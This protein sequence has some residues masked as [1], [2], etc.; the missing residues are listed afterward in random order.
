MILVYHI[1]PWRVQVPTN[2]AVHQL[3]MCIQLKA[4]SPC[5]HNY[6][7]DEWGK[8]KNQ[9]LD[10]VLFEWSLC[11]SVWKFFK[12]KPKVLYTLWPLMVNLDIYSINFILLYIEIAT[13][14]PLEKGCDFKRFRDCT[15]EEWRMYKKRLSQIKR[16]MLSKWLR[17]K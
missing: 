7:V 2:D 6:R 11:S 13:K 14:E 8:W 1:V 5:M 10:F 4:R 12:K 3:P 9:D 17:F 15:D 16:Q